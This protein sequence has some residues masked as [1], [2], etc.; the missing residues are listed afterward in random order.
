LFAPCTFP[1]WDATHAQ[2]VSV[3]ALLKRHAGPFVVVVVAISVHTPRLFH[4]GQAVLGE[5]TVP[6]LAQGVDLAILLGRLGLRRLQVRLGLTEL[7]VC[8]CV[9]RERERERVWVRDIV[10]RLDSFKTTVVEVIVPCACNSRR[11]SRRSP[12]C[13]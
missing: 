1:S 10:A 9:S 5:Q 3:P 4:L 6:L 12:A 13:W 2:T 11:R 8:V 7:C